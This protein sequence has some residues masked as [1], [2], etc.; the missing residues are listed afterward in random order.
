MGFGFF[1]N[2]ALFGNQVEGGGQKDNEGYQEE[3][4]AGGGFSGGGGKHRFGVEL[5]GDGGG[6]GRS[7]G[8]VVGFNQ[9]GGEGMIAEL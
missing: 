1:V 3:E 7:K 4:I 8:R 9:L 2:G 6:D 5:E